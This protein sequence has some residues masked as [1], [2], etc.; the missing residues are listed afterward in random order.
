MSGEMRKKPT[1]WIRR[2]DPTSFPRARAQFP[3]VP[4]V[5]ILADSSGFSRH[6]PW[7]S[8]IAAQFS[9]R[10]DRRGVPRPSLIDLA[11]PERLTILSKYF[12]MQQLQHHHQTVL[13]SAGN[14]VIC[15][16]FP[17]IAGDRRFG[18]K[19]TLEE[20]SRAN[21]SLRP[22]YSP[23]FAT[24]YLPLTLSTPLKNQ[25]GSQVS[26]TTE[27]GSPF[28]LSIAR[29]LRVP[30]DR[31]LRARME[32]VENL[33]A[34][35]MVLR[36]ARRHRRNEL[37]QPGMPRELAP[38][39]SVLPTSRPPLTLEQT[40]TSSTA[41][42]KRRESGDGDPIGAGPGA[43]TVNVPQLADEVM[44]QLDR[45]LMAVRERMGRI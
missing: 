10:V 29:R 2:A 5:R 17:K 18:S 38:A 15:Q 1:K 23:V 30:A 3:S 45:R 44:K 42:K 37:A 27:N 21:L 6:A 19:E 31:R 24:K 43:Q 32:Y 11:F 26:S 13:N 34:N 41:G 28:S 36:I 14:M 8:A 39:F 35:D 20:T 7:A 12:Y 9:A 22:S 40:F 4:A 16:L 33:P 25:L